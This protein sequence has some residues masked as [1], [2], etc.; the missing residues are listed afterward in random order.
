MN[1]IITYEEVKYR[2]DQPI[3]L[4]QS[5]N[6]TTNRSKQLKY[7][8]TSNTVLIILTVGLITTTIEFLLKNLDKGINKYNSIDI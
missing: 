8:P 4:A 6:L 5:I 3:I 7:V 1:N 2:L